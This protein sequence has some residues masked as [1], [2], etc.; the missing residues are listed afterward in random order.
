MADQA[1]YAPK[2]R[3]SDPDQL[4][5][6]FVDSGGPDINVREAVA[7]SDNDSTPERVEV[8]PKGY[9]VTSDPAVIRALDAYEPLKRVSLSDIEDSKPKAK[10]ASKKDD[11]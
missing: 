1:A 9:V 6:V 5:S 11:A 10:A 4:G 3:F 7:A 8:S 2:E